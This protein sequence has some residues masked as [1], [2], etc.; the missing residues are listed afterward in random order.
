MEVFCNTNPSG[1]AESDAQYIGW[2]RGL[3]N[4]THVGMVGQGELIRRM[5][6]AS[7]M[8][9]PNPW[10]ET[11]CIAMIEAMAAGLAVIT[12]DRAALPETAAGFAQHIPLDDRD[13]LTCFDMPIDYEK[14]ASVVARAV[15]EQRRGPVGVA[16]KL[17][18]QVDYFLTH[19]QW[20]QRVEGW[21]DFVK[22]IKT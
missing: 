12:T 11:S 7:I 2:M 1:H 19:Y 9:A 18:K 10:P 6:R 20:Q 3:P 5:K 15:E 13:H 22:G 4:V 8:L 21:I 17:R 16:Q 14:F